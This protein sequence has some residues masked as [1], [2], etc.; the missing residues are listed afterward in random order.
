[1]RKALTALALI[2]LIASMASA[3][4]RGLRDFSSLFG[5]LQRGESVRVVVDYGRCELT[6]D[7]ESAEAPEAVGGM[8][9]D[10]WEYFAPGVVGNAQGYVAFS[11]QKLIG[12]RGF[13]YNYVRFRVYADETVEIRAQYLNPQSFEVT[14]DE[15]FRTRIAHGREG[16]ASFYH[17]R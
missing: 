2:L 3:R 1:M 16:A 8:T 14:M 17:E 4:T 12:I 11:E 7:G 6:V 15:V 5:A 9:V 13:V 10:A